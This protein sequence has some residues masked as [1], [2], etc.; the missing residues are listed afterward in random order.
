VV[1][2]TQKEKGRTALFL[3][4]NIQNYRKHLFMFSFQ[5]VTADN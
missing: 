1:Y 2:G 4:P 3:C 5:D